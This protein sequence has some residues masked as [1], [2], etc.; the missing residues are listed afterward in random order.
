ME[1]DLRRS[2][3]EPK[4]KGSALQIK[5]RGKGSAP[6]SGKAAGSNPAWPTT[7]CAP[8]SYPGAAAASTD[9]APATAVILEAQPDEAVEETKEDAS[10][11]TGS[12]AGVPDDP[13][14]WEADKEKLNLKN[15]PTP[16]HVTAFEQSPVGP[17]SPSP[18]TSDFL[19]QAQAEA[20]A[21]AEAARTTQSNKE[22][23]SVLAANATPTSLAEES[24]ALSPGAAPTPPAA[25]APK[26]PEPWPSPG[27]AAAIAAEKRTLSRNRSIG[28]E[29]PSPKHSRGSSNPHS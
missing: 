18:K 25:A 7:F 17:S 23:E 2:K 11:G 10:M 28:E 1:K 15:L 3:R 14:Q 8:P 9:P 5:P 13:T 27:E 29:V 20:E 19:E 12:C 4:E 16:M 6:P 26:S 22:I 24:P 21:R